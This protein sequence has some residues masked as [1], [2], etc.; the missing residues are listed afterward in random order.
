MLNFI[1]KLCLSSK[2]TARLSSKAA[3]L[4]CIPNSTESSCC[5]ATLL[6]MDVISFL[7]F[8][9]F[10]MCTVIS[11]CCLRLE[12][13]DYK[14]FWASIH[15]IYWPPVRLLWRSTCSDLLPILA[16]L[17]V[18]LMLSLQSFLIIL[19]MSSYQ[20]HSCKYFLTV[21][22]LCFHSLNHVIPGATVFNLKKKST[23]FFPLRIVFLVLHIKIQH[24]IQGRMCFFPIFYPRSFTI[25]HLAFRSVI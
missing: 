1:F 20:W 25:L 3:V 15:M 4:F 17:F 12:F 10:N 16:T 8:S 19:D 14:W 5:S 7:D 13:S 18:F 23:L 6:A 21:C 9:H 24:Q 22:G 11:H 2:E